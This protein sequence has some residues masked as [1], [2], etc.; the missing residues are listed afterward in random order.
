MDKTTGPHPSVIAVLEK[1]KASLKAYSIPNLHI[2]CLIS[3]LKIVKKTV[4]DDE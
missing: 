4:I 2:L 3:T 1:K